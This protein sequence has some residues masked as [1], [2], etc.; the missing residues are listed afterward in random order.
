MKIKKEDL[1]E[2]S[3]EDKYF[4]NVENVLVLS[5]LTALKAMKEKAKRF[6]LKAKI[7]TDNLREDIK[8]LA[9][10]LLK[11]IKNTKADILLVGGETTVKVRGE[12]KGGRNQELVMWFLKYAELTELTHLACRQAGNLR[13]N[14]NFLIISINSD[15]WDKYPICW[16]NW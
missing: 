5:N 1:I 4:K 14:K 13:K 2:T 16:S 10:Y 9:K 15:G 7:L 6:G 8:E 3:K 12:G 11:E